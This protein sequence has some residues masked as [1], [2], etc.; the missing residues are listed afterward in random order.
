MM[1]LKELSAKIEGTIKPLLAGRAD[2]ICLIDPPNH[3]N[4]GDSAILLGELDFI[5]QHFPAARTS[6]IDI[7]TYSSAADHCIEES[8]VLLLHGGGNFGDIW[9]THHALR[10]RILERFAHKPVIQL[11]QSIHFD[12]KEELDKTASII[13]RHRDFYMLVRDIKSKR[14]A[15]SNFSCPVLLAPDMAFA[16]KPIRRLPP[17]V[18]YFCL[19]RTDKE[20]ICDHEKIR[21]VLAATG[22]EVEIEDWLWEPDTFIL[23]QNKRLRSLMQKRPQYIKRLRP[24]TLK[25]YRS[26]AQQRV[27]RGIKLL[28]RGRNVVTDRLHGHIMC[29]LLG[30]PHLVFDSYDKKISSFNETWL[31]G[32]VQSELLSSETALSEWLARRR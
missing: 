11:P 26:L 31:H 20:V 15:D 5:S 29:I 14:F 7:D 10:L 32:A 13:N 3:S 8:T 1:L 12:C 16:M 9:P 24:V 22:R 6:L 28:S 18:D 25:L 30:I 23:R 17:S 4:V 19:L 21:A 27:L 2:R